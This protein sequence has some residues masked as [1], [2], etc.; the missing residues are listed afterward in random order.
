M[1]DTQNEEKQ[2]ASSVLMIRPVAFRG[3]PQTALS[4]SFQRDP[5]VVDAAQEQADALREFEGLVGLLQTAGVNVVVI[6]DTLEPDTPDSIFPNNWVSFHK[7][8]CVVLYPMMAPNRRAERREDIL[9]HLSSEDGFRI[10]EIVDLSPHE[11]EERFLEGTGSLVLDRP[12]RIAYACISPRTSLELI[13]EFGQ[14]INY[15]VVGFNAADEGG[16]PIYHTNVLMCIGER[17]AVICDEAIS[18][19]EQRHAVVRKLSDTGHEVVSIDH[20]QLLH[21]VGN[22][23]ELV[24]CDGEKLLVM[25]RRAANS[26]SDHQ[27][28]VLSRYARLISVPINAIEDSAGGSVRCMLAEIHL[29]RRG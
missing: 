25:S 6:D 27:S 19:P 5:G 7:D 18:D 10:T 22:M 4:N 15:E 12:N 24:N 16:V 11:A 13:A 8:G 17:F 28:E 2:A 29:P 23:L 14:R 3:N 20:D 1:R 9:E 26:L 21:F